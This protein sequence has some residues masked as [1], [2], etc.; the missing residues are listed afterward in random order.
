VWTIFRRYAAGR[1]ANAH[2][3][4]QHRG[5]CYISEDNDTND[6]DNPDDDNNANDDDNSYDDYDDE[7]AVNIRGSKHGN[8]LNEFASD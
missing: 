5:T 6:D 1:R 2:R 8:A 3:E 4:R 7:A